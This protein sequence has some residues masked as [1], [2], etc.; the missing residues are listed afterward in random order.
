MQGSGFVVTLKGQRFVLTNRHVVKGAEKVLVGSDVAKLVA[1]PGYKIAADL[2]LAVVECPSELKVP[3]LP[4]AKHPP[5]PGAEV[6]ALGF[7]LGIS[8]VITRGIVS[9]V[10]DEYVLFDAPISSGNSGGPLV[11]QSGEVIAVA[12]LGAKNSGVAIVQNLN[13]GIRVSAI[14]ALGLFQDPV[15]RLSA[16]ADRIREVEAFI[17]RGYS[18]NDYFGLL[19]LLETNWIT[20]MKLDHKSAAWAKAE[21]ARGRVGALRGK[22]EAQQGGIRAAVEKYVAFLKEC[23]AKIES[24]PDA[25]TGLGNDPVL[26][27]FLKDER[28]FALARVVATPELLP[29]MARISADHWLARLE[30]HRYRLEWALR[31]STGIPLMP[32]KADFEQE[33]ADRAERPGIRLPLIF[34][35][36]READLKT[37]FS[38]R[39]VWSQR[40][41]VS[42]DRLAQI[43]ESRKRP[44]ASPKAPM[45]PIKSETLH[46]GLLRDVS[47]F[48]QYLAS[49]A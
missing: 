1:S 34:T 17:E 6:L 20:V 32:S 2:D 19:Q 25:F 9:G 13:I 16:L 27:D 22:L 47:S 11:N 24:L 35:G 23:E 33:D 31:Y 12:T 36:D 26:F 21:L 15:L 39:R 8:R 46:G 29:K 40:S 28:K 14:P 38:T 48:R 42:E 49:E 18:E 44:G 4:L 5:K 37:Y 7:P 3:A 43:E 41:D 10:E 45:D 30:D